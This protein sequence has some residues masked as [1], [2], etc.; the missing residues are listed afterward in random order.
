MTGESGKP[1]TVMLASV[2]ETKHCLPFHLKAAKANDPA[3]SCAVAMRRLWAEE[4]VAR[5]PM[6]GGSRNESQNQNNVRRIKSRQ[7]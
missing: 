7:L 4:P 3:Y 5:Q 6:G 2:C 1:E